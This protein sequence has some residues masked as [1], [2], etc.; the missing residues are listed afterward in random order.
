MEKEQIYA[1]KTPLISVIV[2]VYK[3]EQFIYRCVDSILNQTYPN[4]EII[5]VDDGSPDRSGAICDEYAA[6][7][8]RIRVIHQENSGVSAARNAGL[9]ICTGE[10]IAFVDSDDYLE[11]TLFSDCLTEIILHN[12]DLVDYGFRIVD[13]YETE[14]QTHVH[15]VA[16]H[17]CIQRDEIIDYIIPQLVHTKERNSDF[18]GVWIWNK[19]FRAKHIRDYCLRFHSDIRIWED[20]IFTIEY[21]QYVHRLVCLS[22]CYYNYRDTENSL[23]TQHDENLWKN[24]LVIYEKYRSMYSEQYDFENEVAKEYRFELSHGIIMRTFGLMTNGLISKGELRK[25]LG[26][27][28]SDS[29]FVSYLIGYSHKN[30]AIYLIQYMLRKKYVF[31]A[32]QIYM[33]YN[34]YCNLRRR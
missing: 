8:N 31:G 9:D 33:A 7:D 17:C 19:I 1:N 27:M 30:P 21:M 14:K 32:I 3:V 24:A 18:L 28:F 13:Q 20:G 29:K 5:L 6:K 11:L 23:S 16:K 15:T 34:L 2:P 22:K 10:Y 25:L 12:P 4:L 26:K